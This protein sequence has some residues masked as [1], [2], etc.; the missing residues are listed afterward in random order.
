VLRFDPFRDLD[1][2]SEQ[3]LGVPAGSA[4][5][6]RFM[7]M[8][9]Y[10]SGDRFVLEADLPGVDPGSVDIDVDNGT[11]TI[12][13]ERSPRAEESVQWIASERFT[14]SYM[15]QLSLGDSVDAEGISANYANGVLTVT[16]PVAEKAKPRRIQ[17]ESSADRQNVI[18][19]SSQQAQQERMGAQS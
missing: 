19:G 8:D 11:L 10:R 2:L 16:I 7:P 9:L 12:R 3:L 13:A 17:V 4:R 6:P 14:G 15:R 18:A 1:R 5:S